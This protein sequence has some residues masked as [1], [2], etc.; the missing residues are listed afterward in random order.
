[1][2]RHGPNT[3][4]M[5]FC[6]ASRYCFIFPNF[7]WQISKI[8]NSDWLLQ[9]VMLLF[10]ATGPVPREAT[11]W[12]MYISTVFIYAI[13]Y[14]YTTTHVQNKQVPWRYICTALFY[15][16]LHRWQKMT[17]KIWR[18]ARPSLFFL[19]NV[20]DEKGCSKYWG[21]YPLICFC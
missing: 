15:F 4:N 3:S 5:N 12:L 1:M 16:I 9:I 17:Q 14:K 10:L 8:G 11:L 13:Y 18:Y 2:Y 7:H 21:K 19:S 6:A 20:T